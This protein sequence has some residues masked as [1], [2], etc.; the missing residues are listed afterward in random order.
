MPHRANSEGAAPS[1][2]ALLKLD[3]VPPSQQFMNEPSHKR[4]VN[5]LRQTCLQI[6]LRLRI[7]EVK[8]PNM[9][10]NK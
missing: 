7:L 9:Y 6:K 5:E 3:M 2:N 1:S 4:L 10:L 8:I